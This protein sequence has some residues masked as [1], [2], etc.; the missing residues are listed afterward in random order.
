[1]AAKA[2]TL[3][4]HS[5]PASHGRFALGGA[6]LSQSFNSSATV[7]GRERQRKAVKGSVAMRFI[8]F[9][10]CFWWWA[11][12]W[13]F[14]ATPSLPHRVPRV[15]WYRSI[16]ACALMPLRYRTQVLQGLQR[17]PLL[18]H[19]RTMLPRRNQGRD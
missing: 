12:C 14:D 2:R 15:L 5:R 10:A 4:P 1:M 16:A 3:G 9:V 6:E 8:P 17:R 13:C 11:V 19:H 18:P 7:K